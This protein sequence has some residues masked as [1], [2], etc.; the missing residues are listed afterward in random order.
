VL[1]V[2]ATAAISFVALRAAS[3]DRVGAPAATAAPTATAVAT[4]TASPAVT[5]SAPAAESTVASSAPVA[6]EPP[7]EKPASPSH[8]DAR[9]V[10][11]AKPRATSTA[12]AAAPRGDKCHTIDAAGIWHVK[13]ECL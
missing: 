12:S 1:L 6:S 7:I 5:T 2:V 11:A 3:G 13:P 4:A 8:A 9:P 10:R